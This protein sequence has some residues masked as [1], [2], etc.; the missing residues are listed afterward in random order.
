MKPRIH[1]WAALLATVL[2]LGATPGGVLDVLG[3]SQAL[4]EEER[5]KARRIPHIQPTTHK[6]LQQAE[7]L[8]RGDEEEGTEPDFDAARV[9]LEDMLPREG[10]RSRYNGNELAQVHNMLAFVYWELDRPDMTIHHY[11]QVIAQVPDISEGL[12]LGTMYQLA[13][14][15]F[16]QGMSATQ[17][18]TASDYY[19][20]TLSMMA[21]WM[22]LNDTVGPDVHHFLSQVYYQL[23]N[24]PKSIESLETAIRL[25]RE[26]GNVVKEQWWSMLQSLHYGQ[27]N[28]DRCIEVLEILVNEYPK[29]DYW[30]TLAAVYGEVEDDRRQLLALEAAHVGGFLTK[31]SDVRSYGS[32]LLQN[33]VP[34][35]AATYVKQGI[36][37]G[38]VEKSLDT[39]KLEGQ[40]LVSAEEIDEAIVVF[41]EAAKLAEDGKIFDLLSTLYLD[42]DAF[43]DC[44]RAAKQ[45]LD[46]GGL[47]NVL[48]TKITLASCQFYLDELDD[49]R[50]T[51]VDVRRQ[52]R[53]DRES[54][55]ERMSGDWITYIDSESKRLEELARA[56]G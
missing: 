12:E 24:H 21:R 50:E 35:R 5:K 22:A 28:W 48:R 56:G 27:E 20:R 39:L 49:A 45:A 10:R 16:M 9:L 33:D 34:Y 15:Y 14:L 4:A 3:P 54:R 6:R 44:E 13:K 29:R 36:D 51:F 31:E 55:L 18:A 37:E 38:I 7:E 23:E 11:E 17:E 52:A 30:I 1:T 42:K 32:L 40:A 47:M 26:R 19:N 2:L 53:R 25:T 41:E 46:K 43:A 8:V